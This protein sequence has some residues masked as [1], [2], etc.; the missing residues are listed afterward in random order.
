MTLS[1]QEKKLRLLQI[2]FS[3]EMIKLKL[4]VNPTDPDLLHHKAVY[5][6]ERPKAETEHGVRATITYT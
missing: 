2:V 4:E 3:H 6:I 1:I 5:D